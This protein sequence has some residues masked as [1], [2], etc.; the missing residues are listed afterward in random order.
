M[1][2]TGFPISEKLL[3]VRKLLEERTKGSLFG[4]MFLNVNYVDDTPLMGCP[5][6]TIATIVE[7]YYM[8]REQGAS[9]EA[10][11]AAIEDHRSNLISGNLRG[12]LALEDYVRYRVRLEHRNG[13]QISDSDISRACSLISAM[14][15]RFV[16][17]DQQTDQSTEHIADLCSLVS[18]LIGRATTRWERS[19][20]T[21]LG[22]ST[23]KIR[24]QSA[25]WLRA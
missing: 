16:A 2:F 20:Q 5:E 14:A 9:D 12:R 21:K 4:R 11:V 6:G 3:L 18:C 25:P 15:E 17:E 7:S 1:A 10:A 19:S 13:R 8:L 24:N 22:S 23:T